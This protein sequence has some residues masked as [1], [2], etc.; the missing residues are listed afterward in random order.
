MWDHVGSKIFLKSDDGFRRVTKTCLN[1]EA[2]I[3]TQSYWFR[4]FRQYRVVLSTGICSSWSCGVLVWT[5][6]SCLSHCH[7]SIS[8][9]CALILA[10]TCLIQ[11]IER[12][13]TEQDYTCRFSAVQPSPQTFSARPFLDSTMSCDV[14][15]RYWPALSQTSRGQRDQERTP[16]D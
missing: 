6:S 14:T 8:T 9:G 13:S 3:M 15:E 1:K 5:K 7:L 11:T 12:L 4:H 16:R 10:V 2:W